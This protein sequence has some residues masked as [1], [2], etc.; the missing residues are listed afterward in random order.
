M[1]AT[2]AFHLLTGFQTSDLTTRVRTTVA[3]LATMIGPHA[4]ATMT[5]TVEAACATS[6]EAEV[7]DT[8]TTT[9]A[10]TA[11][12][13][14]TAATTTGATEHQLS[15]HRRAYSTIARC[16]SMAFYKLG[17]LVTK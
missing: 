13:T 9:E 4:A 17:P 2:I 10:A 11:V 16:P 15:G 8:A 6:T 1:L 3:T 5:T 12:A 14:M 7:A